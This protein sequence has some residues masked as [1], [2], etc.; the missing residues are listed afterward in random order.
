MFDRSYLL[1]IVFATLV[2]AL[3]MLVISGVWI[4]QE[5]DRTVQ[6]RHIEAKMVD[7]KALADK[8]AAEEQAAKEKA[9]REAA[10]KKGK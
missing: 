9:K 5:R 1:P 10:K 3:V 8:R 2:H 6:P 4:G 7:L